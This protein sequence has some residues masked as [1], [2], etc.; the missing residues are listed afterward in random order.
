[1]DKQILRIYYL[2]RA[3]NQVNGKVYIG[4]TVDTNRRWAQHRKASAEVP[5]HFA[6]KK[7]GIDNFIFEV[8]ATC[9]SYDDANEL[10][11]LLVQQY[12]CY[13]FDG[14]GYNATK[15]GFNAPKSEE[16]KEKLRKATFKQIK[17]Q[18][19]PSLGKKRTDEQRAHMSYVRNKYP[20]NYTPEMREM[21][22]RVHSGRKQSEESI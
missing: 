22:S 18:G 13:I 10:E 7:H 21:F 16:C 12:D 20:I 19:H 4:Q 3:T 8:I 9:K 1:M 15:G 6:I 14:K 2:Y 11:T 17:E 5:F